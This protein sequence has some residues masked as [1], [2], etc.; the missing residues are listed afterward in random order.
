[1]LGIQQISLKLNENTKEIMFGEARLQFVS[2]G[3]AWEI[4]RKA[5]KSKEYC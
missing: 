5:R 3:N 4:V 1:M 2:I